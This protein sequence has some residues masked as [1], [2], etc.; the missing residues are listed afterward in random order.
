VARVVVIDDEP[1]IRRSLRIILT[2][3]GYEA[4]EAADGLAGLK[5]CREINP[6]LVITDIHMPGAD[7]IVTI[8]GLREWAPA[9][10]IIAISGGDESA[11]LGLL[12][13]AR[14]MGAVGLLRKPFTIDEV[15]AA[16]RGALPPPQQLCLG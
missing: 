5:L 14:L 15:L 6:D 12:G 16:V 2:R 9:L 1:S 13:S 11:R 3:A 10:P 8:A 7:G 4:H